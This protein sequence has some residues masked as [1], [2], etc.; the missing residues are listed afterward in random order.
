[1]RIPFAAASFPTQQTIDH[2]TT[3]IMA[4]R[5]TAVLEDLGFSATN[6]FESVRQ[7]WEAVVGLLLIDRPGEERHRADAPMEPV[8]G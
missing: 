4:H 2:P 7:D 3:S 8:R 5:L 1:M 6:F